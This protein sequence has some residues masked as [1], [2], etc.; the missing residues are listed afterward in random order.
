MDKHV[1]YDKTDN[2]SGLFQKRVQGFRFWGY[3]CYMRKTLL[4]LLSLVL[5]FVCSCSSE[6]EEPPMV[7]YVPDNLQFPTP[8]WNIYPDGENVIKYSFTYTDSQNYHWTKQVVEVIR[9]STDGGNTWKV[10]QPNTAINVTG[11]TVL[12]QLNMTF[13]CDNRWWITWSVDRT[14]SYNV[15]TCKIEEILEKNNDQVIDNYPY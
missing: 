5:V 7:Q 11:P 13:K 4:I 3:S 12:F 14:Y 15:S 8:V 9:Y 6:P 10:G 2:L 1:Y